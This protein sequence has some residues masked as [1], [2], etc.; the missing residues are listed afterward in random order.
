MT[1]S[2]VQ[3]PPVLLL[4]HGTTL[5][6]GEQ[7]HIR[8]Y[9]LS[10]GDKA[11]QYGIK[12]VIIMGAHWNIRGRKVRVATNTNPVPQNIPLVRRSEYVDYKCT[13][14]V[15]TAKRCLEMLRAAGFDS[16][17]DPKFNWLIDTFP[18]LLRMF[19]KGCP[20]VTII[21]QNQ[22]FDPHY[23][24]EIG[25]VLR[26]LRKEGY[27]FIGSGGGVHNLYRTD[28][29]YMRTY[30]DN[31]AQERPPD[32]THLEFRQAL[33]DVICKNGGGPD[34]KRGIVR[35]MKHPNYRDA[36]GTDDHYMP[37]CFVAGIV[38]EEEDRGDPATLGAEV[39][40]L[41]NQG[42]TQFAIGDWPDVAIRIL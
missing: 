1:M 15:K 42:E 30:R 23:H 38:G 12:G 33:E 3:Q 40:E 18:V 41:R 7:S 35:L 24:L 39:W 26:P 29:K 4:S 16:E 21:S 28:W 10:H 17:E 22:Y 9:W 27:L 2:Q 36:H 25:R 6:T 19:P 31:F 14:D 37:T 8:D 5:L 13:A 20:P 34:L 11:I 32:E